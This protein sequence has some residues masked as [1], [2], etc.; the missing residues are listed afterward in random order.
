MFL[1]VG[2][3]NGYVA[4]A[5]IA[6]GIDCV[7]VEPGINGAMAARARAVD[8]VICAR[9]EDVNL[10]AGAWLLLGFST[11]WNISKMRLLH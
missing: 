9:L 4:K 1:D 8:P 2:G 10:P 6:A 7:L 3:G 5:L 11:C